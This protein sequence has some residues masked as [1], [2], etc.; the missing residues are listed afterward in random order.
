MEST[1]FAWRHETVALCLPVYDKV[2]HRAWLADMMV[3]MELGRLFPPENLAVWVC[4]KLPQPHAQNYLVQSVLTNRPAYGVTGTPLVAKERPDWMLWVEDDSVP[5]ANAFELLRQHADPVEKPVMHGI[6]FDRMMPHDPSIWKVDP[7][8]NKRIVP[9]H[10]WQDNT[11]YRVAHS[12]TCVM[13]VHTSVW[14]RLKRPWFRMQPFEPGVQGMI[15]CMS[16]SHRMRQA[17]VPIWAYTG[18]VAGHIGEPVEVNAEISR[19]IHAQIEARV[20]K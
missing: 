20:Q 1:S 7:E 14:E 12:G 8:D 3:A 16:L 18:C 11:L 13:L 9:I 15:P 17:D 19:G 6:S 10:G 4:H 2:D 5:P